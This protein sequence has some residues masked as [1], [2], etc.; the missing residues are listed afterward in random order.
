MR[1]SLKTALVIGTLI[2]PLGFVGVQAHP[3]FAGGECRILNRV[4]QGV[5]FNLDTMI[6]SEFV[7][8]LTKDA[9][10]VSVCRANLPPGELKILNNANTGQKCFLGPES[11]PLANTTDWIEIITANGEATLICR[12]QP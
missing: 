3:F 11:A 12:F 7:S 2:A 1:S 5:L 9:L 10:R 4:K 8:P 6:G